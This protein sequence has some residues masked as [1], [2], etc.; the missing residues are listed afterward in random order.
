MQLTSSLMLKPNG[1]GLYMMLECLGSH[2]RATN[3][4]R[5]CFMIF[6]YYNFISVKHFT[7]WGTEVVYDD[8][9]AWAWAWTTGTIQPGPQQNT[10][11]GGDDHRHP[12]GQVSVPAWAQGQ[13]REGMWHHSCLCCSSQDYHSERWEPS[14]F[15]WWI[16]P[17]GTHSRP[18]RWQGDTRHD[19][20]KLF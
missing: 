2:H 12:E 11:Q 10:G 17:R 16:W 8:T 13:S 4:N 19:L 1:Q 15:S 6:I 7:C 5:V 14:P 3:F 20:P 9:L 18:K